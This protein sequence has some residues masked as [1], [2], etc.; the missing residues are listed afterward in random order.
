MKKVAEG[1][2]EEEEEERKEVTEENLTTTTLTVG[3][4]RKWR[5]GAVFSG[6]QAPE[7]I[8]VLMSPYRRPIPRLGIVAFFCAA[9]NFVQQAPV[10]PTLPWPWTRA[11]P[12]SFP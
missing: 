10:P 3:N 9:Y 8:E 12:P 4:K 6:Q 5:C 7:L 2:A 11:P 1:K